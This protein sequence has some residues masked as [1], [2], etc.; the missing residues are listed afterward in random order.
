VQRVGDLLGAPIGGVLIAAL[1]PARVLL[2]DAGP[3]LV[4]ATLIAAFVRC[5]RQPAGE[6][7]CYLTELR[8]AATQLVADRLLPAVGAMCAVSNALF[9]G[10]F[11][12]LLPA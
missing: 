11:T 6:R 1:G 9:V 4:A 7:A 3:L 8:E 5:G 2:F 12:V 10:L